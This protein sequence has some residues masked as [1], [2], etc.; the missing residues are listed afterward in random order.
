MNRKYNKKDFF[1]ML[2][3]FVSQIGKSADSNH[4]KIEFL[5]EKISDGFL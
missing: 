1:T 5:E 4:T 2:K 3:E